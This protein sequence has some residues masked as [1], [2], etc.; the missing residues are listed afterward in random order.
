[1]KIE[2]S[3]NAREEVKLN[4]KDLYK[5]CMA[6]SLTMQ[7]CD[8][9]IF[10]IDLFAIYWDA[11]KKTGEEKRILSILTTDGD[12]ISTISPTAIASFESILDLFH[13]DEAPE[14]VPALRVQKG[15]AK[16]GR[17]FVDIVVQ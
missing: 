5:L 13:G 1:M 4:K 16:S 12:V 14:P 8:G 2:R 10:D 9:Q 15:K 6:N 11:D 3:G 17:D 7:K